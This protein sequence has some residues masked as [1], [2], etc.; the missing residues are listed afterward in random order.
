M[1]VKVGG[2]RT[3]G[4]ADE[5]IL[6]EVDAQRVDAGDDDV[7]ADVELGAV[8][9]VGPLD[10]RLHHQGSLARQLLP[11]VDHVYARP[12]RRRRLRHAPPMKILR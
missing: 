1:K 9:E 11:L 4:E 8:D 10:V 2:V 6:V 12:P 7:D 5:A 3:G